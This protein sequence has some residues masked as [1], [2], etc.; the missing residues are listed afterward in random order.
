M[1]KT[2]LAYLGGAGSSYSYHSDSAIHQIG[3]NFNGSVNDV[4]YGF[5][6]TKSNQVNHR[7]VTNTN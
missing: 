1:R 4:T 7:S 6:Y 5:T 3:H 2:G